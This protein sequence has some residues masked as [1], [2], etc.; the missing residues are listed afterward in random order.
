MRQL[1]HLF[2]LFLAVWG[3]AAADAS[4]AA[5][6][7]ESF[8]N[9]VDHG[10][11]NDG[12]TLCSRQIQAIV[13]RC[14]EQGGGTIYF[15]SGTYLCGTI[16]LK[17]NIT[18]HLDAGALILASRNLKD[19][20]PHVPAYRSYT[21]FYTEKSVLYAEKAENIAM[22]GR[23]TIDGQGKYFP[24]RHA[25][26]SRPYLIRLIECRNVRARDVTLQHSASWTLHLLACED[27]V[28]DGLRIN[29]LP[30]YNDTNDGIDVDSSRR[31]RIANCDISTEDDAIV[32]KSTSPRPCEFVTITNCI[33]RSER[34]GFKTGTESIGGFRYITMSNC[35]IEDARST[36]I[37]LGAVDGGTCE[38]INIDN[39]V[40]RNVRFCPIFL[41]LGNRARPYWVPRPHDKPS[42]APP[43]ASVG[44]MRDIMITNVQAAGGT[45]AGVFMTGIPGH[46]IENVT[47]SNLR[48]TVP[49]GG[50]EKAAR[51]LDVPELENA[52]PNSFVFGAIPA[53]GLYARHMSNLRLRDVEFS[54]VKADARPPVV[55]QNVRQLD[56]FGLLGQTGPK[57]DC[58][59]RLRQVEDAFIHGCRLRNP[60]ARLIDRSKDCVGIDVTE[61]VYAK[62]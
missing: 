11:P 37:T 1:A 15:P 39:V 22:V 23:G 43:K 41:R 49:G 4:F 59:I 48:I 25:Y 33:L 50:N 17:S 21:D 56:L 57:A 61:N 45:V 10:V 9:V 51:R 26:K 8:V 7:G 53:Y 20:P 29:T 31:V 30:R 60:V 44:A 36:G 38:K 12:K 5:P 28:V 16:V 42:N 58:V 40:I 3:I 14:A 6:S 27:V 13:D 35:I 46:P 24:G 62:P 54:F 32:L 52:Y 55:C 47:L 19:Y 34:N 18:L 2:V